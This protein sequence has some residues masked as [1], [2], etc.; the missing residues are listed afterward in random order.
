MAAKRVR[1]PGSRQGRVH[2]L[3]EAHTYL[4]RGPDHLH[5]GRVLTQAPEAVCA[6]VSDPGQKRIVDMEPGESSGKDGNN[7][8][9]IAH[10][11]KSAQHPQILSEFSE[12]VT[13]ELADEIGVCKDV[14]QKVRVQR[15]V[16]DI[17]GKIV[18]SQQAAVVYRLALGDGK[19]GEVQPVQNVD[20]VD[21][22]VLTT[23]CPFN[24]ASKGIFRSSGAYEYAACLFPEIGVKGHSQGLGLVPEESKVDLEAAMAVLRL[25]GHSVRCE[26]A[27]ILDQTLARSAIFAGVD[28]LWEVHVLVHGGASD[29]LSLGSSWQRETGNHLIRIGVKDLFF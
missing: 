7:R 22:V 16:L 29:F 4:R 3:N 28:L 14:D 26:E 6:I 20:V 19:V 10:A 21:Y 25:Q 24:E 17:S 27:I 9:C 15:M 12:G 13:L 5:E 23:I 1:L 8:F 11:Q 18:A 2:L